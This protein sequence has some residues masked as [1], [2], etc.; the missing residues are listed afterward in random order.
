MTKQGLEASLYAALEFGYKCG[1]KG[2][3]LQAAMN[4]AHPDIVRLVEASGLRLE[5]LRIRKA[6]VK[7]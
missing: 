6:K 2:M 3:N 5:I 1:E 4:A 7:P